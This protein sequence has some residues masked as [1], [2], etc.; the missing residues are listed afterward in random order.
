MWSFRPDVVDDQKDPLTFSITGQPGWATFDAATGSLSGIPAAGNV[1]RTQDIEITV[2]DGKDSTSIGPFQI[3]VE[4]ADTPSTP[5]P[6]NHAP[7]ITGTPA[8]LVVALQSYIFLP[9]G[10]DADGDKL[11]YSISGKPSWLTFN[12]STGQLSGTP[13]RTQTGTFSNIRISV[14][15]GQAVVSLPPFSIAVQPAPIVISG[16]PATTVTAGTAYLFKPSVQDAGTATFT[17]SIAIK[18]A[19]ATFSTSTCQLSG[20]P[21]RAQVATTSN[22]R[23]TATDGKVTGTLAAFSITV[24]AAPNAAPTISGTPATTVQAGSPYSFTPTAKDS[25][26]DALTYSIA[27]KPVWASFNT[28]TGQLSGTPTSSQVTTYADIVIT[29]SDGKGGTASLPAFSIV[30]TSAT[31]G[32]TNRAP[33][34]SGTPTTVANAGTAYS[35]RPTAADADGDSLTF[36]ISNKPS[37]ATFN[38]SNG[39]LSGTPDATDA[40]MVSGIVITVSDG[41]GGV[42]SLASFSITVTAVATGSAML[43]WLPPTTNT[44]GSPLQNLAGYRIYYGTSSSNLDQVKQIANAGVTS[45]VVDNLTPATWY[46]SVRAY[47]SAGTESAASNLAS[48]TIQ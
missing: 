14:S 9:T 15:D 20:T 38:A 10:S 2:S 43:S 23:I 35:W 22:I 36:S 19:W 48:K 25:N 11:T 31:S 44:D 5:S 27:K 7:T 4:A 40:G 42:A 12:S 8:G 3:T 39:T 17:W 30:V 28:S 46:F 32:T 45:D 34:I 29:V 6:T 33:T 24:T 26:G 13:A 21:T 41:K 47:T 16:T 37:W 18:P 1:G